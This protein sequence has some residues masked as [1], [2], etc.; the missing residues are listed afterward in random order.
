M[1]ILH[2]SGHIGVEM[3]LLQEME[4]ADTLFSYHSLSSR[5]TGKPEVSI[6]WE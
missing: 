1:Y 5:Y 6:S 3:L 4:E 2:T